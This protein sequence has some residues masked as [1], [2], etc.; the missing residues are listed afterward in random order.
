MSD[1]MMRDE[2]DLSQ[3]ANF[4][5]TLKQRVRNNKKGWF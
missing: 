2:P 3:K 5:H 4:L 1:K